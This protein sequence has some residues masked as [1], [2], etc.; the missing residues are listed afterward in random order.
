[1]AVQHIEAW[2][3]GAAKCAAH[4]IENCWR[5]LGSGLEAILLAILPPSV[6]QL[7]ATD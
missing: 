5:Y 2:L 7:S 4:F 1:M 3:G 6:H